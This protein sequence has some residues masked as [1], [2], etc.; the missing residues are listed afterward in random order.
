MRSA[1]AST[2]TGSWPCFFP[3]GPVSLGFEALDHDEAM[4]MGRFPSGP[5][6]FSLEF[7]LDDHEA[8][9]ASDATR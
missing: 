3:S 2:A 5:V 9:M 6:S 7:G 1:P 4:P 8:A